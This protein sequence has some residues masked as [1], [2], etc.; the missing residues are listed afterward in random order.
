MSERKERPI[1]FSGAMVR[2]L[3]NG[4][5]TQT[6][7]VVKPMRGEQAKWL[8]PDLLNAARMGRVMTTDDLGWGWQ[9][10][11]P[12]GGPL[13]W[14]S[15]PYGGPGDRLWVRETW[16][17]NG[18]ASRN[19]GP[20]DKRREGYASYAAD[21]AKVTHYF[22]D[23]P[24]LTCPNQHLPTRGEDE[25]EFDH[26]ERKAEYLSNYFKRW[27][28]SIHMPRWA[29]RI[30]LEVT[31]VRVER[32]DAITDADARAEGIQRV[33]GF[34]VP[35]A[36]G[37]LPEGTWAYPNEDNLWWTSPVSAY[38]ALWTSIN[39]PGSWTIN[40]WVWVV[41]FKMVKP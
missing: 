17:Y 33:H 23:G 31:G 19:T 7:R 34:D 35:A 37:Q 21:G 16:A 1:L 39:G 26:G 24:M 9:M 20:K 40:P 29:S 2:A 38:R 5:K 18:Q 27:R 3:L 28:P 14:I 11:H 36:M 30:T 41:E 25:D 15:S 8:N 13:G 4:S 12:K 22:S 10:D 32:L 6:R